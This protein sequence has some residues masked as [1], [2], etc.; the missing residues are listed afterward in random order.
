MLWTKIIFIVLSFF[1]GFCFGAFPT[2]SKSCRESPKAL[3]FANAFAAGVFLA[4]G[5]CHILPEQMAAWEK[6]QGKP[7]GVE[8]FPLPTI[9]LF[10]GY[11][12]ILLLDKVLFDSSALFNAGTAHSSDQLDPAAKKL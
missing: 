7:E 6:Y 12:I 3:G 5:F 9:L 1:E 2:W 4:I 8:G 10:I 11:A